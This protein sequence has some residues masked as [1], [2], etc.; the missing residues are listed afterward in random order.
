[1]DF[2]HEVFECP[3]CPDDDLVVLACVEWTSTGVVTVD[4]CDC[5]RYLVSLSPY[6][7]CHERKPTRTIVDERPGK[8]VYLPEPD[9][10]P[11]SVPAPHTLAGAPH[12]VI[13]AADGNVAEIARSPSRARPRPAPAGK[14][15]PAS[16][17][18]IR[19]D[20]GAP[21]STPAAPPSAPAAPPSA[22]AAPP[23]ASPAS[24]G[25]TGGASG[26]PASTSGAS[27]SRPAA[28]RR[29][30]SGGSTGSRSSSSG[31]TGNRGGTTRRNTGGGGSGGGG[32][33]RRP[34][35]NNP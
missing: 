21:P 34:R 8:E 25:S 19:A 13:R 33:R 9:T 15:R 24:P 35:G 26:G 22:P 18:E 1:M 11:A 3:P 5:R 32:A 20:A 30:T 23:A 28:R 31:S 7:V 12:E 17:P 4:G 2:R 29:S 16:R 14:P 10:K 27:S 6:A